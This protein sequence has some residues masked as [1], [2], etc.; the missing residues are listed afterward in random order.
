MLDIALSCG[1]NSHEAFTRA[2]QRQFATTPRAYRA[3]G[4]ATTVTPAE[5]ASHARLVREIG[6]CIGLFHVRTNGCLEDNHMA[7][8]IEKKELAAQ[9][10]LV[11]SRRVKRS[12]IVTAITEVL[13]HIFQYAQ[14][15]GIAL[16][17]H[18]FTRYTEAALVHHG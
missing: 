12:E 4:F 15:H 9:P 5:A 7:Y 6:P 13:P 10:V 16:S 14:Q 2:F 11:A 3:R 17:G 18:P 1:F 8:G